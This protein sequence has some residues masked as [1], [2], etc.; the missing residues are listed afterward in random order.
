[1]ARMFKKIHAMIKKRK[2]TF[3][4]IVFIIAVGGYFLFQKFNANTSQIRY[5]LG[6]VERGT[7]A[8]SISGTGQ[9]TNSNQ[10]DVKPKVSGD[11]IFVGVKS[12]QE[13]KAGGLI[14]QL[15]AKDVQKSVRDAE[16]N[17]A[18]AR[19]S[20]EKLVQPADQ[21]SIMQAEN[22]LVDAKEAKQK[23]QDDLAK[24]YEDGFTAISDAFLDLPAVMSG[25]DDMFFDRSIDKSQD[26]IAWYIN[27]TSSEI[28]GERD[29]AL[30]YANDFQD[31]YKKSRDAFTK[32]FDDYKLISRQSETKSIES[33]IIETYDA[34]KIIVDAVKSAKNFVD[35]IQDT[36]ERRDAQIPSAL[37]THQSSLNSFTETANTHISSLL[38]VKRVIETSKETIASSDRTI[39]ERTESLTRLKAGADPLDIQSQHITIKQRENALLDA[40]ERYADYFVRAP[41]EGVI[42]KLDVKKGDPVSSATILAT[43]VTKQKVAEISLNEVD[44]AKVKV[45]QKVALTFDAVSDLSISGKVAE[46]DAMGTVSQ[47]VV[48]YNIKIF[49]DTQDDRVKPGMT[50]SANII[51][52]VKPDVIMIPNFALK[53]Q[54]ETY[55]VEVPDAQDNNQQPP[56]NAG[57]VTLVS[58][59]RRQII[60]IG[61]ANDEFTEILSGLKA[62]DQII[63]STINTQATTNSAQTSSSFRIP[64]LPGGG[65]TGGRNN[66][67]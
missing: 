34:T 45:D 24:A 2:I 61:I 17:L 63:V 1:M 37:S 57:A 4:V 41:F 14:A 55:Y 39:A 62:G 5:V 52:G 60:E 12:G 49:F 8:A 43:L 56:A 32:N 28:E 29:R 23:S 20:L 7:I 9:V 38:S 35:F 58:P 16:A 19:L 42:A 3:G 30:R 47:G 67:R 48:S 46:I 21:L 50:V 64:G 53:S 27:Q 25:M 13:V 15:N 18:A 33:L 11:V 36:L 66:F 44:V 65:G 26:N 10:V 6:S 40:R 31:I 22:S 59:P 51:I 54:N